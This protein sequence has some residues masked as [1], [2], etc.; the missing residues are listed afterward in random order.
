M[1]VE[2]SN[3]QAR[4]SLA[5]A[6]AGVFYHMSARAIARDRSSQPIEYPCDLLEMNKSAFMHGQTISA[7][8][9]VLQCFCL[10]QR[11]FK[12]HNS[13][14]ASTASTNFIFTGDPT[15][16]TSSTVM[17]ADNADVCMLLSLP[18]EL[19][20]RFYRYAMLDQSPIRVTAT[21]HARSNLLRTCKQIHNE[22]N[23]IF[24]YENKFTIDIPDHN[25]DAVLTWGQKRQSM[26]LKGRIPATPFASSAGP[27]WG[28]FMVCM[29]RLHAK[30]FLCFDMAGPETV[31]ERYKAP[32]LWTL[33]AAGIV[34]TV[35]RLR[36][37]PWMEV[38]AIV[39]AQRPVLAAADAR[40]EQD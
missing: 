5:K 33:I 17:A 14:M 21:G 19:R 10:S 11:T 38:E 24:Y 3:V 37:L 1:Y 15:I 8:L 4:D 27:N 16:D 34:A 20:N 26:G 7:L 6:R 13:R 30:A 28:N 9:G 29:R 32:K 2:C 31:I 25:S 12:Q 23:A 18:G 40:W 22:A 39:K 35:K 36:H